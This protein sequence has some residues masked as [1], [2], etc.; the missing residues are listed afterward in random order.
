MQSRTR[1]CTNTRTRTHA[2][3]HKHTRTNTHKHTHTHTHTHKHTQTHTQTHTNTHAQTHTNTHTHTHTH[4]HTRMHAR[5]HTLSYAHTDTPLQNQQFL[6]KVCTDGG[7]CHWTSRHQT[8]WTSVDKRGLVLLSVNE[9]WQV[10][11]LS[12]KSTHSSSIRCPIYL[13]SPL[14]FIPLGNGAFTCML[15]PPEG[16]PG[17]YDLI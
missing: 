3:T 6:T 17:I 15:C 11:S 9:R 10:Y 12:G 8:L 1:T 13:Y 16:R 7:H 5:T 2:S 4:T 14:S